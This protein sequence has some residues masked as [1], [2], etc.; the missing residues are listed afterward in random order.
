MCFESDN[1]IQEYWKKC[2]GDPM[3]W[4]HLKN[5]CLHLSEH[6]T[7]MPGK[8]CLCT[9]C[10]L[11]DRIGRFF[12]EFLNRVHVLGMHSDQLQICCYRSCIIFFW[13]I[14]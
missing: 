12:E 14:Q 6:D 13:L 2:R 7:R 10:P 3:V 1:F 8:I 9:H 11:P 4:Q 5:T